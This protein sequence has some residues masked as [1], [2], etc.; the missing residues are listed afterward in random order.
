[1]TDLVEVLQAARDT[2]IKVEFQK[3]VD[4]KDV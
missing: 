4:V 2:I 3:K 1:M